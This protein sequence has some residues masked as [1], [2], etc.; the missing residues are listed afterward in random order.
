MRVHTVP[1]LSEDE[2]SLGVNGVD[3][4]LPSVNLFLVVDSRGVRPL[5]SE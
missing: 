2:T 5:R 3:D 4:L 1:Q